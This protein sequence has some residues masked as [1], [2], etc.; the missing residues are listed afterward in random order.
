MGVMIRG[1]EVIAHRGASLDAPEN[2][3]AAVTAA[4]RA[5]ATAVECDVHRTS[6]GV[7]VVHHDGALGRTVAGTARIADLT[8]AELRR[9]D[10]GSWFCRSYADQ[11]VP[12]LEEWLAAV[13]PSCGM[14]VEVK[15]PANYPGI[16]AD[17]DGVLRSSSA[18]RAALASGRLTV[19]SFAHDWLQR[20]KE[21]APDVSVG[22]LVTQRPRRRALEDLAAWA[23]QVNPRGR[24]V[25]RPF[26]DR[27][28]SLGLRVHPWT[29]DDLLSMRRLA[30]WGVDGIITND[31]ARLS[32]LL[33]RR[34]S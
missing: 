6:D 16:A 33:S 32:G 12:T 28:H 31:P 14:F 10:A 19:Q 11:R 15:Q 24:V 4:H 1:F 34:A 18:G 25:T 8:W 9:L 22:A 29:V 26:V 17:L 2:T 5:A 7:L 3:L 20:F 23:E 27:A 13:G 21:V 30:A